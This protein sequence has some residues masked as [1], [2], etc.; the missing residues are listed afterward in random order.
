M[1]KKIWTSDMIQDVILAANGKE[2][3]NSH[4]FSTNHPSVYAA[5]ERLFGSWGNAITACGL[6]YKAIRK[7]RV[8][9]RM[10][11]VSAIKKRYQNGEPL[12]S[13]YVQRNVKTLYMASIH[14]FKSWGEAVRMAGLDYETI[15]IRRSMTED[16][17][18]KE[19][20]RLYGNGKDL[21]YPN[22]RKNHQYLL[23]YGMKKL[24]GGSWAEA[25]RACGIMDNFRLPASK[26]SGHRRSRKIRQ[27]DF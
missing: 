2:P 12:S 24:G 8:W 6:D 27:N 7:Y 21:A 19:I 14:H 3:L 1:F 20:R 13:N 25:R 17:I 9:N 10:R 22:M 23:A 4:Y 18:R 15:R 11:I 5:A 26:R 16:Q